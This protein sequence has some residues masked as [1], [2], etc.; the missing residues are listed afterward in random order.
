MAAVRFS[1]V[2]SSFESSAKAIE[3]VLGVDFHLITHRALPLPTKPPHDA[4]GELPG[5]LQ[6]V[7][8]CITRLMNR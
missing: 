3:N 8:F 2:S 4:L 7:M 6:S 5:S 1:P